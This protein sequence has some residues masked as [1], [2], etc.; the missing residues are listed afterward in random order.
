VSS[1]G[2]YSTT[3]IHSIGWY[4]SNILISK[5]TGKIIFLYNSYELFPMVFFIILCEKLSSI[6]SQARIRHSHTTDDI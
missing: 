5:T 1:D 6:A 4:H 2:D 3:H